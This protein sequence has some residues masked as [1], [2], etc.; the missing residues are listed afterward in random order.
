M[1]ECSSQ[2]LNSCKI[3]RLYSSLNLNGLIKIT[4]GVTY[5]ILAV[6]STITFCAATASS[7]HNFFFLFTFYATIIKNWKNNGNIVL[8]YAA[9]T[10]QTI[11]ASRGKIKFCLRIFK[12]EWYVVCK[13]CLIIWT[14]LLVG[15]MGAIHRS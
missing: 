2:K 8:L 6:S 10:E 9:L 7:N 3:H 5:L 13:V 4:A 1:R 15:A 14:E 12:I 11:E